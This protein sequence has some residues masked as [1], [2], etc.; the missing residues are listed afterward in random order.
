MSADSEHS[1]PVC[2]GTP[3]RS[4]HDFRPGPDYIYC[5]KCGTIRVVV[6][7]R[8]KDPASELL[9]RIEND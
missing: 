6:S 7:A 3:D 9:R 8:A 2:P 4:G 5:R 1:L